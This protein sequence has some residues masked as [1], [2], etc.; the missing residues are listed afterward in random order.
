MFVVCWPAS[1]LSNFGERNEPLKNA[2]SHLLSRAA[3]AKLIGNCVLS[4][5]KGMLFFIFF[6]LCFLDLLIL[7]FFTNN[8]VI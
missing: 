7:S 5:R 1:K 6:C 3:L 4:V 8:T 2:Y